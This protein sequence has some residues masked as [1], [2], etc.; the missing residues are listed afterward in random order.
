MKKLEEKQKWEK[1]PR[2]CTQDWYG[3]GM[4]RVEESVEKNDED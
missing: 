1:Y 2:K 3:Y 4:R